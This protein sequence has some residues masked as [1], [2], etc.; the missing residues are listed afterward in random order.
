[1]NEIVYLRSGDSERLQLPRSKL[2][3]LGLL[4]NDEFIVRVHED[5]FLAPSSGKFISPNCSCANISVNG[6]EK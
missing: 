3:A 1:M 4:E 6:I 2:S 5:D